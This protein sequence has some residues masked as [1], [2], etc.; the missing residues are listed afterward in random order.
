MV[1]DSFAKELS[2][3]KIYYIMQGSEEREYKHTQSLLQKQNVPFV[4]NECA[5]V[6]LFLLG[7]VNYILIFIILLLLIK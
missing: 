4:D 7:A 2:I 6:M 5:F 3:L 1:Y